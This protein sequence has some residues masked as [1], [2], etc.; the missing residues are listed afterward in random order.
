M[1]LFFV[2]RFGGQ[3]AS[4]SS[5]AGRESSRSRIFLVVLGRVLGPKAGTQKRT[6]HRRLD[7]VA[8]AE[9]LR[10]R[11]RGGVECFAEFQVSGYGDRQSV[12]RR[13]FEGRRHGRTNR[14]N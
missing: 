13:A 6:Y 3:I 5:T 9:H 2:G 7:H 4:T 8:E 1:E 11:G 14:R 10:Q 12:R